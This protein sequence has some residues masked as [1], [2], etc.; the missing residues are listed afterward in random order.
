MCTKIICRLSIC[1]TSWG[2][3]FPQCITRRAF[4]DIREIMNDIRGCPQYAESGDYKCTLLLLADPPLVRRVT[5]S[6]GPNM[7]T[8]TD[9]NGGW[10]NIIRSS[11]KLDIFWWLSLFLSFLHVAHLY[12]IDNTS[13]FPPTIH[14]PDLPSVKWRPWCLTSAWNLRTMR[15]ET[16][17]FVGKMIGYLQNISEFKCFKRPPTRRSPPSSRNESS[18]KMGLLLLKGFEAKMQLISSL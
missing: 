16:W 9:E 15:V 18:Q 4:W 2:L 17:C 8:P 14:Y 1:Q 10:S 5:T 11:G 3:L 12:S 7:S 6:H 13:L